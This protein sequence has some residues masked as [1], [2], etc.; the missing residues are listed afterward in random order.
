VRVDLNDR[1]F[2]RSRKKWVRDNGILAPQKAPHLFGILNV[3]PQKLLMF[4]GKASLKYI[5]DPKKNEEL[6]E[7]RGPFEEPRKRLSIILGNNPKGEKIMLS[8]SLF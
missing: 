8:T 7:E 1:F 6:F 2:K 3:L 4:L 5:K